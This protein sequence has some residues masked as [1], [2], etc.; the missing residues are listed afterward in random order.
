MNTFRYSIV[1]LTLGGLLLPALFFGGCSKNLEGDTYANEKPVVWFVN[2]PPEG[3]RSSINPIVNWYGQDRDG[4]IDYY[5]YIVVREGDM[6]TA[7]G[8]T[9][10]NP[11]DD[12]LNETDLATYVSDYLG[13]ISDTMWTVLLVRADS[14][15]PHTS[16]IVPMSAEMND[17]VMTFVPQ[18]VFVQAYDEEGLGSDIA[19]RRFLRN[20]NPPNTRIIGFIEGVPFINS[21]GPSGPAT[22]IRLRWK[23]SDVIDYPTDAPPFEFQWKLFGPYSDAEYDALIDSFLVPVFVTN[24]ARVFKFGLPAVE[25]GCDTVIDTTATPPDTTIT[26]DSLPTALIICDTSY[27]DTSMVE[28]CDTILIDTLEGS[29]IYGTVDTLLRVYDDDFLT[30]DEF[31]RV[32]DSSND[33][34]GNVW[35]TDMNE[36]I[37]DVYKNAPADT[38]QAG[39]FIFVV[40]SRDDAEVPDLTP[41]WR[42]FTVINPQHERDVLVVLWNSSAQENKSDDDSTRAFWENAIN[43]WITDGRVGDVTFDSALDIQHESGHS[44]HNA[45]LKLILRYKV[46]IMHQDAEVSGKWSAQGEAVQNVITALQTGVNVWVTARVPLG[47]HGTASQRAVDYASPDYQYFFGIQQT[48]FPGWSSGF[49]NNTDGYGLGLPRTEHFIGTLSLDEDKWPELAVDSVL[50][51]TRYKWEGSIDPLVFPFYP[52]MSDLGALPQVGWCV[53]TFD[54][55][56]MYLFK[57][58]YGNEHAQFTELS[59]HGRPVCV[60]LNRGLFRTVHFMFTPLALEPTS[61]G[62]MI[63]GVMDW[64]FDGR[65]TGLT[66]SGRTDRNAALSADL[67]NRY[68]QCYWNANGDAETFHE[69]LKNAY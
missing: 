58:L 8:R 40:R 56:A 34:F 41:N 51:R 32:A 21:P 1:L 67:E 38:T 68:W 20:D 54:T 52:Y 53:R 64:L 30:S 35:V 31:Y 57:S 60:R 18:Y 27:V 15:D 45:M 3:S 25:I 22:G 29:N 43:D 4:Q 28:S 9:D 37:Y 66:S 36:T 17:P 7:M 69:L 26:C 10:W 50:L 13:D 19:F 23:G 61:A 11:L 6:G 46:A 12:P 55:E 16:N 39:T 63:D 33:G 24:D 14:T 62:V 65:T 44:Q 5:R 2:V 49:F 42:K 48:T 47:S 59:Y